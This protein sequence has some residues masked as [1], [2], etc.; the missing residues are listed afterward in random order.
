MVF[1]YLSLNILNYHF[2]ST[3]GY[4]KISE[5]FFTMLTLSNSYDDEKTFAQVNPITKD[6]KRF[7]DVS[8][9]NIDPNSS[10]IIEISSKNEYFLPTPH[11]GS[12][13]VIF[14]FGAS[15]AGKST[16]NSNYGKLYKWYNPSNKIYIISSKK[17]SKA[18]DGD[19]EPS[20][21]ILPSKLK[22]NKIDID[23][24]NYMNLLWSD[25]ADSLVIIDDLYFKD[26]KTIND[27]AKKFIEDIM[28]MGREIN[29]SLIFTTHDVFDRAW[30]K[31][32]RIEAQWIVCYPLSNRS[33][34][35][36]F[37]K[38]MD[39]PT[40]IIKS[41]KNISSRWVMISTGHPGIYITEKKVVK[42]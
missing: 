16:F 10:R 26:N 15:G 29:T 38:H 39:I 40:D 8:M 1:V 24:D 31:V 42:M 22:Y 20:Y 17:T 27:F 28:L 7:I 37:L 12:R 30:T 32:I 6:N 33:Q 35:I 5:N 34:M 4:N 25:F 14:N 23:E 18:Y 3:I 13:Q 11:R 9:D 41:I 2:L 36:K 21:G 19:T